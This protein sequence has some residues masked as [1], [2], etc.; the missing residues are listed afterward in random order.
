M[1]IYINIKGKKA[2]YNISTVIGAYTNSTAVTNKISNTSAV[3]FSNG[4][5]KLILKA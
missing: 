2:R 1:N 5:N 3:I 4:D